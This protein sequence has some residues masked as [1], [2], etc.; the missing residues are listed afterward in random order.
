LK[1]FFFR[2]VARVYLLVSQSESQSAFLGLQD[3]ARAFSPWE[4]NLDL[5]QSVKRRAHTQNPKKRNRNPELERW[6]MAVRAFARRSVKSSAYGHQ[7][8]G[9]RSLPSSDVIRELFCPAGGPTGAP[10]TTRLAYLSLAHGVSHG[11][12]TSRAGSP[13]S[14]AN[15]S[16][17]SRSNLKS[18]SEKENNKR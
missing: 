16:R 11:R 10:G 4:G 18:Q 12:D 17:C 13:L 5:T 3:F 1:C 2:I 6:A 9:R 7:G 14:S 8:R 15:V